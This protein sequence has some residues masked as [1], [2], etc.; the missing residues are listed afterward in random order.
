MDY[1]EQAPPTATMEFRWPWRPYQRRVLAE[2]ERHLGD[3]KLHIVAAP[4][5]GKTILGLEVF[6][7]QADRPAQKSWNSPWRCRGNNVPV[8]FNRPGLPLGVVRAIVFLSPNITFYAC[9]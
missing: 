2:I 1:L 7:R 4:G 8:Q 3:R 5:S 9:H 6:R